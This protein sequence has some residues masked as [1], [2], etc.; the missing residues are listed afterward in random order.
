[1]IYLETYS[2]FILISKIAFRII[3]PVFVAFKEQSANLSIISTE[4]MM[5]RLFL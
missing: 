2:V 1:M 3:K 5:E 4:K